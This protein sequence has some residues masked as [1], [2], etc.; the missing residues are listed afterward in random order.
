MHWNDLRTHQAHAEDVR[1]LAL[2]VFGAHIDAAF[3]T[4]QGAGQR[5]GDAVLAGAGF[6]DNFRFAHTFG[7]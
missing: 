5:R 3:Q 6:G 1:R 7:E 2:D 4:E